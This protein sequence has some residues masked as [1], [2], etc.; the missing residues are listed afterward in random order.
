[1]A[2]AIQERC[3][4]CWLHQPLCLCAEVPRIES[5]TRVKVVLH[6]GELS[7][8]S[9]TGH[10]IPLALTQAR[11]IVRGGESGERLDAQGLLD[12]ERRNVLLYPDPNA[13]VLSTEFNTQDERPLTLIV[14]DGSWRQSR[15]MFCRDLGILPIER[16]CLPVGEL[17]Q[18]ELRRQTDPAHCSTLEAVARA[19]GVLESAVLQESLEAMMTLF[20]ER[21]SAGRFGDA[22]SGK[23]LSPMTVLPEFSTAQF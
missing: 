6:C 16:V 17:S 10:L 14:P 18:Y 21:A 7:R 19:L 2:E 8:P 11:C 15:R 12:D 22:Y 9:N 23:L 20:V 13:T 1:M 3:S 4:A 5:Q